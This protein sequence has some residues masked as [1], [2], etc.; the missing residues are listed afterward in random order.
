MNSIDKEVYLGYYFVALLD[1]VGQRDKLN[2]LISLP[3]NPEEYR[4]N[5][6]MLSE[7]SE[8]VKELRKQFNDLFDAMSKPTGILNHLTPE[9]RAF[10]EQRKGTTIWR[11]GFSDSYLMTVPCFPETRPG[12]HIGGV[13][14]CLLAICGLA[15]WA[16]AVKKPIRGGVEVHLGTEIEPQEVYGPVILRVYQLESEGAKYPRILVGEGLLNHLDRVQESCSDDFDSKHTLVNIDKCRSLKTTDY[17]NLPMLDFIGES[18]KALGVDIHSNMISRA[19][20]FI[21]S[22]EKEFGKS[23]NDKLRKRYSDLRNYFESRLPFWDIESL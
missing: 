3:R 10:V 1:I 19:Y 14:A 20:Q 18:I 11:R 15:L 21:V 4:H 17:D 9:Q 23:G 6:N 22:Q 16:L 12:V 13:Y 7:A 8:F 5:A 2:E